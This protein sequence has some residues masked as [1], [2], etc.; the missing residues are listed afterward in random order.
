MAAAALGVLVAVGLL[1]RSL[2]RDRPSDPGADARRGLERPGADSPA[3]VMTRADGSRV[4]LATLPDAPVPTASRRGVVGAVVACVVLTLLTGV[5]PVWMYVDA[6]EIPD[7]A[8]LLPATV[9][10]R[11]SA[12]RTRTTRNTGSVLTFRL[13][14][15]RT[16]SVYAEPQLFG[17]G[18]GDRIDVYRH[19]GGWQSPA[20]TSAGYLVGGLLCLVLWPAVTAGYVRSVRRA[21]GRG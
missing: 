16:G 20:R 2:R 3:R 17:P 12:S 13:A 4:D 14:D 1:A 15:G 11:S 5:V 7:G 9:V 6:R 10:D 19:D 21:R 8:R 18:P